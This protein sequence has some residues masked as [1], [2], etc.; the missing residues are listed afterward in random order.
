MTAPANGELLEERLTHSIIGAFFEVHKTL[1]Y[2]F[3]ERIYVLALERELRARG[4]DVARDVGVM[5]YYRDEPLARQM[6]DL[7]VDDKVVVEVKATGHL[8][9]TGTAQLFSY[10]CGTHLE[11]GLL[12][13]F[14]RVPRFHRIVFENRLKHSRL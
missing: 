5:V 11:V 9:P 12:L 7:V 4:Y 10:L 6:L 2:G 8:H 1:G 3:R 14:G 13:H